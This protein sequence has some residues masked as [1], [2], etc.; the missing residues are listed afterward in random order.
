MSDILQLMK[1]SLGNEDESLPDMDDRCPWLH[2]AVYIHY[3]LIEEF[4]I[5]RDYRV[6]DKQ[7]RRVM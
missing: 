7:S 4:L 2:S 5:F 1:I 6:F 3:G